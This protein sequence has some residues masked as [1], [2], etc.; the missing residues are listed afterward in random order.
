MTYH[1]INNKSYNMFITGL[2]VNNMVRTI[3]VKHTI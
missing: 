2:V 3:N 1:P